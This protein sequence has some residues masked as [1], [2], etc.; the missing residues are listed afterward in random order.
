PKFIPGLFLSFNRV[1]HEYYPTS[2]SE[3]FENVLKMFDPFYRATLISD[4]KPTGWDPDNQVVS[5]GVRYVLP[6]DH[7]EFYFE[8]GRGDH[9]QDLNDLTL[10]PDHNRAYVMGVLKSFDVGNESLFSINYE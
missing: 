3:G 1:Y 9:S 7:F 4:D 5:V 10:H 2:L 6:I 8:F